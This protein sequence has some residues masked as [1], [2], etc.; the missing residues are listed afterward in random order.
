LLV[1]YSF[2]PVGGAGVQRTVK[3]AKFLPRHGVTPCV[4]TVSNPSVPLVDASFSPDLPESLEIVRTRTWEPGYGVKQVAWTGLAENSSRAGLKARVLRSARHLLVPDPQILWVPSASVALTRMLSSRGNCD[5]VLVSAPPFS[6]YLL[7]PLVKLRAGRA[8]VLD[9]RDEWTTARTSYELLAGRASAWLG[10][11]LESRLLRFADAITTA[12]E[13]FRASL[14]AQHPFL[15]PGSVH[16]IPNGYDPEDFPDPLPEPPSDRF[17]VS[18]AGTVFKLT[19]ARGLLEAVRLVHEREPGLAS[20]LTVRFMG[21][22]VDTELPLFE[23]TER[24]GVERVGY[25]P[26][27][28]VLTHLA[29][30]HLVLCLLDEVPGVERI[31]PAKIFELMHLGR[32]V[33]TLAPEGALTRLVRRHGVGTVLAPRDA[34]G[35]ADHL[36][37]CL[38]RFRA[39][40][41]TLAR[42]DPPGDVG[43]YHRERLAGE[44][45]DVLREAVDR[46]RRR[47]LAT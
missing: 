19:S 34:S 17:V 45:A 46:R 35:I 14:L 31:Y 25:V 43:R 8:L 2:Y 28:Q 24:L 1:S 23:G 47:P 12:T 38:R 40:P 44:F 15:D 32:P 39:D 37:Q 30:S 3:L 42:A 5:A 36:V 4:L 9:Y 22:I 27:D 26:H 10:G 13:E 11:V 7:G 41:Q 6:Q 18:Y 16:A 29:Q 20:K 33:L 21:R